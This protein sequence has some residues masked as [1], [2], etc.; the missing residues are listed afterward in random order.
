VQQGIIRR[1]KAQRREV[2][3]RKQSKTK[4]RIARVAVS[5]ESKDS[6]AER[7]KRVGKQA[8]ARATRVKQEF[9]GEESSRTDQ[10]ERSELRRRAS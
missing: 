7:E 2:K 3:S 8:Q 4:R 5:K 9:K 1:A 6:E 10:R